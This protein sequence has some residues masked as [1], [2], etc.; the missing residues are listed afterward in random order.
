M[1]VAGYELRLALDTLEDVM[2]D[3]DKSEEWWVLKYMNAVWVL[4]CVAFIIRC[5]ITY[6]G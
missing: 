6:I 1:T 4:V 5:I 2:R 3:S